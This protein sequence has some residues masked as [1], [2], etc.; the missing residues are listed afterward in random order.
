MKAKFFTALTVLLFAL[1]PCAEAQD[2]S[3]A[4][5][6]FQ[7]CKTCDELESAV[8][9][10]RP[11][12]GDYYRGAQWNGLFAAYKLNCPIV[13][14]ALIAAGANPASGGLFGSMIISVSGNWPHDD[15]KVNE[16]WA[17]MLLLAGV[18]TDTR[19]SERQ[20]NSTKDLLLE[21]GITLEYPD[22]Y[23][24]FDR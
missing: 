6:D 10:K 1:S 2:S 22:I 13:G 18:V 17:A 11:N 15:K 20:N 23:E 8:D 24:L 16:A 5:S 3:C 9:L 7:A 14:V 12:L 19:I 21:S 4:P